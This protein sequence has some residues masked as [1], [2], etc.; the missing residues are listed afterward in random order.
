[1]PDQVQ[2]L[3]EILGRESQ[4][5]KDRVV[6]SAGCNMVSK[7]P[8]Q[9]QSRYN[10]LESNNLIIEECKLKHEAMNTPPIPCGLI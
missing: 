2:F 5:P 9:A 8:V 4:L 1:M 7:P 10:S 6:T 3:R